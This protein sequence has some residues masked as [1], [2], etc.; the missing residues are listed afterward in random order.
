MRKALKLEDEANFILKGLS[1]PGAL[2]CVVDRAG[3]TN[4]MA[5]GWGLVGRS[6]RSNPIMV[7]AV[8][9]PRYSWRMLE[10]CE[11]FVV[12]VGGPELRPAVQF[13]GSHSGRD[14]EDKFQKARLT[15]IP[16]HHV[17]APSIR[18][19]RVNIECRTY[20]RLHPPHEVLTP[21]HRRLPVSEQ[22]TIYFA[23]IL[24]IYSGEEEEAK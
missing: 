23:E 20:W 15:P 1:D 12:A 17:Q 13:C 3:H 18:E 19:C 6:Y 8:C 16:S 24:G 10:E 7:V 22:H 5:I 9:P 2:L 21:E 4:V 11:D 14:V